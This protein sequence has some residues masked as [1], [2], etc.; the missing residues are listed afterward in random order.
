MADYQS[1]NVSFT[2]RRGVVLVLTLVVLVIVSVLGYTLSLRLAAQQHRD[3]YMIDYQAARYACDSAL[4]Y[5]VA[6]LETA[7]PQLVVRA[8]EPDFS[9][10]FALTDE[11]YQQLLTEWARTK[12]ESSEP[13]DANELKNQLQEGNLPSVPDANSSDSNSLA[14]LALMAGKTSARDANEPTVRGPYGPPWPLVAEPIELEIGSATVTIRIE[15]ENAKM[16]ISWAVTDETQVRREA[17]AALQTFCE[18][19]R[20]DFAEFEELRSQLEQV[21]GIKPFKLN[22][23]AIAV[24]QQ[25]PETK[26]AERRRGQRPR[27]P[28]P[29]RTVESTRPASAHTGDFARLFHSSL[30]NTEALARPM[31]QGQSRGE[32]ALKYLGMWGSDKVNVNTAPRHVLEA[33]FTF[34]GNGVEIAEQIIQKRRSRPLKN[35]ADLRNSLYKY[36]DSIGKAEKYI[37]VRS[38]FFTIRV[39]AQSGVAKASAVVSALKDKNKVEKLAIMF[40]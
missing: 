3:Q 28:T 5:A 21:A 13:S 2:Y 29:Q 39:S 32:C 17:Y 1:N 15:D 8:E 20:M 19:M 16:P 25:Q 12:Q 31:P 40:E 10:L 4:K 33:A 34:G 35:F 18:W 38:N 22:L 23:G 26:A 7:E 37:V 30:I 9:D 36:A 24:A 11:Q 27:T 6:A 14:D